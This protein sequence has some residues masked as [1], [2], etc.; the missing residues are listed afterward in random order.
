VLLRALFELGCS[1]KKQDTSL[2][3]QRQRHVERIGRG[4]SRCLVVSLVSFVACRTLFF[5]FARVKSEFTFGAYEIVTCESLTLEHGQVA[6]TA[7]LN[8]TSLAAFTCNPGLLA[9]QVFVIVLVYLV[10]MLFQGTTRMARRALDVR[11]MANGVTR[12]PCATLVC[13][14]V[15]C[16]PFSICFCDWVS[17]ALIIDS[18][19][20]GE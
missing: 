19:F 3:G 9:H 13:T 11:Q 14:F 2:L 18:C 10:Y 16:F 7:G 1:L 20:A 8:Y 17:N 4:V 12:R 15:T 5:E 6:Y